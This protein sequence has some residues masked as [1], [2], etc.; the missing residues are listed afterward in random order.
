MGKKV[1]WALMTP[2]LLFVLWAQ[3][4]SNYSVPW[5]A[6]I[7]VVFLAAFGASVGLLTRSES[8]G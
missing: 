6:F 7:A 3:L 5:W 2:G 4:F 1:G 8:D